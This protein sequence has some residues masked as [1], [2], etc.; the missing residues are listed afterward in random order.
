MLTKFYIFIWMMLFISCALDRPLKKGFIHKDF[1]RGGIKTKGVYILS[2][3]DNFFRGI[4]FNEKGQFLYVYLKDT[5]CPFEEYKFASKNVNIKEYGLYTC[6]QDTL[7][8]QIWSEN[9]NEIYNRWINENGAIIQ[10]DTIKFIYFKRNIDNKIIQTKSI[11]IYKECY[12]IQELWRDVQ[13]PWFENKNWYK[14]GR[15][16]SRK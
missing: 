7:I 1:N 2:K 6:I 9:N 16:L 14:K 12:N 15:H 11:A 13:S 5:I 3:R 4:A 10:N 8:T